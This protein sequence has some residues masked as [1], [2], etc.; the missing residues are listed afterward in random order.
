MASNERKA[1][2]L[3]MPHGTANARL[4]KQLLLKYIRLAN[5]DKC[6]KCGE[7]IETVEELSIEH[8]LPWESTNSPELFWDLDN[9][10]FSHLKCNRPHNKKNQYSDKEAQHGTLGLYQK[11]CRCNACKKVKSIDNAKR[12]R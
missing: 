1:R 2:V 5:C 9:I 6:Y 8:I 12:Y 4:K 3:G 7:T 10:A 11:G